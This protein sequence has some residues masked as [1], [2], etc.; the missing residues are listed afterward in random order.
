MADILT[1]RS[2]GEVTQSWLDNHLPLLLSLQLGQLINCL[3][4]Y[5]S[6]PSGGLGSALQPFVRAYGLLL[7]VTGF[8]KHVLCL[9]CLK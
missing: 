8:Q 4:L 7:I 1:S 3:L 2:V 6:P 5:E 9:Y